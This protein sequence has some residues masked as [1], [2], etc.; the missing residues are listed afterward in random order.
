MTFCA[1]VSDDGLF[2]AE[3]INLKRASWN[4]TLGVLLANGAESRIPLPFRCN[5]NDEPDTAEMLADWTVSTAERALMK[6]PAEAGKLLSDDA[7]AAAPT[8]EARRRLGLLRKMREPEP[9]PIDLASTDASRV[10]LSDARWD[11]AQ[12][13]WGKIARNRY[14]FNNGQWEGMLLKLNGE[15]FE[16]G[17]YA[18]AK[19]EYMF[20][21]GGK[22]KTLTTKF[23]LRDGAANQGSAIFRI[24]GDNKELFRSKIL[25]PREKGSA[26]VDLSGVNQLELHTEGGEGHNRN[27]WAIWADPLL[28]R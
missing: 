9:E 28:E 6:T 25:R 20:P 2:T 21:L 7:I 12:V 27:S 3:L 14:W 15:V 17:I 24:V 1:A 19:S 26:T 18:H 8:D 22:W 23:G 5:A 13:G 10:H 16:K 4:L 11:S